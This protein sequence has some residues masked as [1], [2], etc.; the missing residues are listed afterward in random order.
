[1]QANFYRSTRMADLVKALCVT[2][3]QAWIDTIPIRPCAGFFKPLQDLRPD[4][5]ARDRIK[6]LA[7]RL[8]SFGLKVQH[9]AKPDTV[10]LLQERC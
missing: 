1:M 8:D 6:A 10:R 9:H 2:A 7:D 3:G 5:L 4:V